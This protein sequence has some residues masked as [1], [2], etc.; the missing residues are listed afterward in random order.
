MERWLITHEP[1][2]PQTSIASYAPEGHTT[3]T[4]IEGRLR[5]ECLEYANKVGGQLPHRIIN[6]FAKALVPRAKTRLAVIER[7][8]IWLKEKEVKVWQ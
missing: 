1:G 3:I 7:V 5:L 2:N 6:E 4:Q 8:T